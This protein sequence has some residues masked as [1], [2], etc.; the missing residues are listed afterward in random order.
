[1]TVCVKV[2]I[3]PSEF[4][5]KGWCLKTFSKSA[6]WSD[7][8]MLSVTKWNLYDRNS[9]VKIWSIHVEVWLKESWRVYILK[10]IE[11]KNLYPLLSTVSWYLCTNLFLR[12]NRFI[13]KSPKMNV[14]L[15]FDNIVSN[16]LKKLVAFIY[17]EVYILCRCFSRSDWDLSRESCYIR[18]QHLQLDWR[19]RNYFLQIYLATPPPPLSL[20]TEWKDW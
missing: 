1:M 6:L 8:S 7:S 19:L 13:L 3:L 2:S 18:I 5:L 4:N 12:S 15:C 20:R 14:L 16:S 17:S 9:S 11:F 10:S